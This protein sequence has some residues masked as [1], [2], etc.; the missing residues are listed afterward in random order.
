MIFNVNCAILGHKNIF[1]VAIDSE[2]QV[3]ALKN[4]IIATEPETLEPWNSSALE[5]YWVQYPVPDGDD[6][7]YEAL[8][9]S[10]SHST[11][12]F[13]QKNKLDKPLR[14]LS[15]I[16]G[17]SPDE[18][19]HILIRIPA[20]ESFS[21]TPGRENV[22]LPTTSPITVPLYPSLIS[23]APSNLCLIIPHRPRPYAS[24]SS[25]HSRVVP[26]ATTAICLRLG[27]YR[28]EKR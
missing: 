8:V 22:L 28:P 11:V 21:S 20:S 7:A 17:G 18:N 2:K 12:Q 9:E 24:W 14:K 16:I 10:I 19:I 3:A 1:S 26:S 4:R 15:T 25:N 13:E 6:E 23:I 27:G 5:L